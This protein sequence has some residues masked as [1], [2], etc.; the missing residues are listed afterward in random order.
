MGKSQL[1]VF[2]NLSGKSKRIVLETEKYEVVSQVNDSVI[3]GNI[4]V[5]GPCGGAWIQR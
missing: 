5:V 3:E 4:L 2:V 1:L